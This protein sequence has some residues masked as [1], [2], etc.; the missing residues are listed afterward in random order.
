[1]KAEVIAAVVARIPVDDRERDCIEQ[2]LRELDRL[3]DDPSTSTPVQC[4]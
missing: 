2:F 4:T 3:G 1:L